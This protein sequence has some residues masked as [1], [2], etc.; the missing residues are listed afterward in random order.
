MQPKEIIQTEVNQ[1]ISEFDRV[2]KDT[3]FNEVNVLDGSF[4]SKTFQIGVRKGEDASISVSSMRTASI[5]AY[6]QT[7][8]MSATDVDLATG[9]KASSAS[10]VNHVEADTVTISGQ[11]GQKALSVTENMTA[12]DVAELVNIN[13]DSTGVDANASTQLRLEGVANAV[14]GST[15][16][17]SVSFDL[18]GKNTDVVTISSSITLG[19]T[20]ATSNLTNLRDSVN[21]Y[22]AQT[23]IEAVLSAD[24]SNLILTQPEGFDIKII[25]VDF[26]TETATDT[27]A[28]TTFSSDTTNTAI[29]PVA[30]AT[31]ITVGDFVIGDG[32]PAGSYVTS[33]SGLTTISETIP[34]TYTVASGTAVRFLEAARALAVTGL[35][36]DLATDGIGVTVFDK[37]QTSEKNLQLL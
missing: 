13:F 17:M 28:A 4:A 37:S 6:Q 14:S 27:A 9:A 26:D 35:S 15:G 1:L 11:F 19:S 23:G 29:I 18:Y 12:K 10:L 32:V 36:D 34:S 33:I 8:D 25:N 21:A 22:T 3:E 16:T 5:G 30:S 24:K 20:R 7:T 31:G 2:T